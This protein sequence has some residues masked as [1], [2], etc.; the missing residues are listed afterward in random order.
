MD[1]V[2][3][4]LRSTRIRV[5][6]RLTAAQIRETIEL[7][8]MQAD[9]VLVPPSLVRAIT[10]DPE[11]D[12]VLAAAALSHPDYLVTGDVELQQLARHEGVEIVS[13]QLFFDI[14]RS[15]RA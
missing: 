1:E 8:R 15:Q 6:Y 13:P 10:G 11:D 12:Y 4:K 7:L 9:I 3:Q 14:F 5:R 2:G